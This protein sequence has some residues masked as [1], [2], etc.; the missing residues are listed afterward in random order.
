MLANIKGQ[1]TREKNGQMKTFGYVNLVMSFGLERV[2]M[3]V[4]QHLTV[5]SGLTRE[6]KLMCWVAVMA[7]HP[8]EG[9]EFIRFTPEYFHWL[10]NQVFSI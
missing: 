5:G 8:E 2:P 1:L 10:E 9:T 6:P 3:L 7:R 4:P